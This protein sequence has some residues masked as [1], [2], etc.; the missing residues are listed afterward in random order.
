MLTGVMKR[1]E[2]DL[3]WDCVAEIANVIAGQAKALLAGTPHHFSFSLPRVVT[4]G[5]PELGPH[6]GRGCLV[7]A[8][9]T[10]LGEIDMQLLYR[11]ST[12]VTTP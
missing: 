8:L 3:V 6:S 9:G 5:A 2:D 4:G 1:I 7:V 10:D 11:E 12:T